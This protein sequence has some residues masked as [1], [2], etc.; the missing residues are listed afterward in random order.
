MYETL[1][2]PHYWQLHHIDI[3]LLI[4]VTIIYYI[5]YVCV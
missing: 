4:I 1:I 5:M 3:L 2:Q